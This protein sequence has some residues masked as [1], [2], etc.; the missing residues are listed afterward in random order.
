MTNI[1]K[2]F[3]FYTSCIIIGIIANQYSFD[4]IIIKD[5][6]T[7][8]F[9][10]L[11]MFISPFIFFTILNYLN[12]YNN[13]DVKIKMSIPLFLL[14]S[15]ITTIIGIVVTSYCS[16]NIIPATTTDISIKCISF[17]DILS[18]FIPTSLYEP[19]KN[20]NIIQIFI[21]SFLCFLGIRNKNFDI[22][23]YH[24]VTQDILNF[25]LKFIPIIIGF[26]LISNS[27]L[28]NIDSLFQYIELLGIM[29]LCYTLICMFYIIIFLSKNN[30]KNIKHI[31]PPY[32]MSICSC[33][34][35]LT[36]PLTIKAS[37][38]CTV[39]KELSD[40]IGIISSIFS[41]NGVSLYVSI[42][43][44]FFI[45]MYNIPL[46]WFSYICLFGLCVFLPLLTIGI[47]SSIIVVLYIMFTN[48]NI[49]IECL[50]VLMCVDRFFDMMRTS[51]NVINSI[52]V[53][54]ICSKQ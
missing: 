51:L 31:L 44:I 48:F 46:T 35:L 23:L 10:F 28:Y 29:L 54:I 32:I 52:L 30:I 25:I 3:T 18:I 14:T 9:S 42:I 38:N 37:I 43:G 27:Q 33:S 1:I 17:K 49:P 16:I 12:T 50:G 19:F 39:T 6:V 7:I 21:L 41:R 26:L 22:S 45:T 47:P 4:T 15:I 34:S 40:I 2:Y 8:Y 11:K 20:C 13:I 53:T 36:L 5:I 24:S